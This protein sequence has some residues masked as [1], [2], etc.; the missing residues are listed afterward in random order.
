MT[1]IFDAQYGV[2]RASGRLPDTEATLI[3]VAAPR[4]TMAGSKARHIR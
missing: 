4:A 2:R 3:D 1:A